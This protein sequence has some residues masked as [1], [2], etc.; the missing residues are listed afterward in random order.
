MEQP[1]LY[2]KEGRRYIPIGPEFSGFPAE[3]LWYYTRTSYG[4][5][6]TWIAPSKDI[7]ALELGA[8][9]VTTNKI[10]REFCETNQQQ[11]TYNVIDFTLR[12]LAG[13]KRNKCNTTK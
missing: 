3:G 5:C 7:P 12:Y 1:I 13:R 8:I 9:T 4:Q 6:E 10:L 2:R 11:S